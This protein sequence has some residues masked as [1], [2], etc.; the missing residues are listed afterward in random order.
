M[1]E[2]T[3]IKSDIDF[4]ELLEEVKRNRQNVR[5]K[6]AESV[7]VEEVPPALTTVPDMPIR[8]GAYVVSVE[9]E[10]YTGYHRRRVVDEGFLGLL[11]GIERFLDGYK[12][13]FTYGLE[14]FD[15][16]GYRAGRPNHILHPLCRNGFFVPEDGLKV[17]DRG[18]LVL[19]SKTGIFAG[20][21]GWDLAKEYRQKYIEVIKAYQMLKHDYEEK[22]GQ[23]R[24]LAEEVDVLKASREEWL[25]HYTELKYKVNLAYDSYNQ[26]RA[27]YNSLVSRLRKMEEVD[28]SI[29][30]QLEYELTM[31]DKRINDLLEAIEWFKMEDSLRASLIDVPKVSKD[32]MRHKQRKFYAQSVVGQVEKMRKEIEARDEKIRQY[33]EQLKEKE[34]QLRKLIRERE[35]RRQGESSAEGEGSEEEVESEETP[36]SSAESEKEGSMESEEEGEAETSEEVESEEEGEVESAKERVKKTVRKIFGR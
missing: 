18:Y 30:E 16:R 25:H 24:A 5:S 13:Y 32:V 19:V 8:Y 34:E 6:L 2:A 12:L 28:A 29:R 20:E 23:L 31:L 7:V 21:S 3:G 35:V 9:G 11:V 10:E 26:Y 14:G 1:M 17:L 33:E 15:W 36:P 22:I 27:L 4:K